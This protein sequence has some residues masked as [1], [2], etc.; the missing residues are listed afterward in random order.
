MQNEELISR[1]RKAGFFLLSEPL[2]VGV[3]SAACGASMC[4]EKHSS[5]KSDTAESLRK[6]DT[7]NDA[8]HMYEH[9]AYA[10]IGKD[11]WAAEE[12]SGL[13]YMYHASARIALI[14]ANREC[15]K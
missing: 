12:E 11:V 15:G 3:I 13:P 4:L 5:S 7:D 2:Q 9:A 6:R 1:L 10:N 8:Q 14:H